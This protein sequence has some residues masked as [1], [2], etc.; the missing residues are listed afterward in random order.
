MR[1][2]R[3]RNFPLIPCTLCGSQPNLQREVVGRMLRDWEH[4]HP[5]RVESIFAAMRDVQPSQLAD[6]ALFDF[7]ALDAGRTPAGGGAE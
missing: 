2:A 7:A 1:S 6:A 4:T 3:A 5:G